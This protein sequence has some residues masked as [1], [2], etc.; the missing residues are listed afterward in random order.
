MGSNFVEKH[1]ASVVGMLQDLGED[2]T[3]DGLQNTP[4]RYLKSLEFLTS[5]YQDNIKEILTKAMFDVEYKDMVIVRNIEFYSLCEHHLIP[6]YGHVH[7]GYIPG[8][9]VVGLSKIPRMVDSFA[10]RLQVQERMTNQIAEAIQ[11]HL[12][13]EGVGVV[14]DAY[15]LCMMMRGVEKQQSYTTTSSVH[16]CFRS[17]E[18][19]QEF[20]KL[21]HSARKEF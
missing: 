19:R 6:F 13:P 2:P 4:A 21:I 17:P 5:G 10:R 20:L 1:K 7:V 14:V 18:T 8:K 12:I 11:E 9:K 15:H 16:G 3:R